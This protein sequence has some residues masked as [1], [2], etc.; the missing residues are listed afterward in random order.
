MHSLNISNSPREIILNPSRLDRLIYA[1]DT[2]TGSAR[3]EHG[4]VFQSAVS[5]LLNLWV[6]TGYTDK[7][8]AYNSDP[9]THSAAIP[10]SFKNIGLTNNI[11]LGSLARQTSINQDFY[12]CVGFWQGVKLDIKKIYIMRIPFSYWRKLWPKDVDPFLEDHVFNGITNSYKDDEK[13]KKRRLEKTDA[14]S[15]ALPVGSPMNW[16][17]KRD[18]KKQMR[19]QCSISKSGFEDIF[20]FT[21]DREKTKELEAALD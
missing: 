1:A 18:H 13:W 20:K 10:F 15:K 9:S 4:F 8:D 2:N 19:I 5:N 11:E 21:Y 3:Q 7:W 12:L 16:H 6:P 14:W 17:A